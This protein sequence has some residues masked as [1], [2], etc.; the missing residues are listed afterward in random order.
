MLGALAE[1]DHQLNVIE[2]LWATIELLDDADDPDTGALY[3]PFYLDIHKVSEARERI[4]QRVVQAA[5]RQLLQDLVPAA[6]GFDPLPVKSVLKY[7]SGWTT[8]FTAAR[9]MAKQGEVALTQKGLFEP[10][11]VTKAELPLSL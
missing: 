5:E 9:E 1:T 3:R 11:V 4:L 7:K 8:T 2:F 10:I 6:S